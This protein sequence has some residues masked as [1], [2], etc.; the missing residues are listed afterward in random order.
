MA[1]GYRNKQ[2]A[3]RLS[4]SE[5]TVKMHRALMMGKLGV[6]TS[7]DAVRLAVEAGL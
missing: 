3:W 4:L 1:A 6:S 5:K 2:I 7:A